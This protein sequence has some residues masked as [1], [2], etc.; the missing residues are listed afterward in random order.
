MIV[1]TKKR[2]T[3]YY[4]I[5]AFLVLITFIFYHIQ[6]KPP[7]YYGLVGTEI[8]SYHL[9]EIFLGL[10]ILLLLYRPTHFYYNDEDQVIIIRSRR[11]FLGNFLF[12]RNINLDLPKRKIRRARLQRKFLRPYLS[13]TI[14]SKRSLKRSRSVDLILLTRTERKAVL[15]GLQSIA[16]HQN[17]DE[18]YGRTVSK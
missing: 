6:N 14:N 7:Y 4:V 15:R 9:F 16:T 13:I 2:E 8:A 3:K 17:A 5:L 11:I 18:E 10:S 1:D 12:K